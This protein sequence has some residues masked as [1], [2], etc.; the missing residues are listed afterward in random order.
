MKITNQGGLEGAKNRRLYQIHPYSTA[1]DRR[2]DRRS[3]FENCSSVLVRMIPKGISIIRLLHLIPIP[4]MRPGLNAAFDFVRN[5]QAN[6]S[7]R[8]VQEYPHPLGEV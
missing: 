3:H 7:C 6:R 5:A 1:Y 8:L 2:P 4:K